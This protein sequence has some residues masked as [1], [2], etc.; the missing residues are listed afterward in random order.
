MA[1]LR[2][3]LRLDAAA[4]ADVVDETLDSTSFAARPSCSTRSWRTRRSPTRPLRPARPV[5]RDRVRDEVAPVR[6]GRAAAAR[7]ESATTSRPS[8]RLH[9]VRKAAKRLRYAAETLA[10]VTGARM[11][12]IADAP[13]T[14]Q[15]VLGDHHDA[16]IDPCDP[17]PPRARRG[18]GG[19]CGLPPRASR[20]RRGAGDC[21]PRAAGHA[22]PAIDDRRRRPG[23]TRAPVPR[24]WAAPPIPDPLPAVGQLERRT[25][26]QLV[27]GGACCRARRA[28][29]APWS[30]PG[31]AR[32]PGAG[33]AGGARPARPARR[34]AVAPWSG[35]RARRA[36]GRR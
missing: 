23:L 25:P 35:R 8:A 22:W 13:R 30:T 3:R 18:G 17:A 6:P 14:V 33:R 10:P 36:G 24:P 5:A 7:T 11:G 1:G 9:Q 29:S 28:R 19:G 15:M 27:R 34:A 4:A 31:A 2:A 32:R 16:V 26:R 12:R 21:E 20:R